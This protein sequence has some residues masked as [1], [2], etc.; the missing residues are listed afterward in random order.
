MWLTAC[1]LGVLVIAP[2]PLYRLLSIPV[3][4]RWHRCHA[5]RVAGL[6]VVYALA[7]AFLVI[8]APR[9]TLPI[10]AG[11]TVLLLIERWRARSHYGGKRQLPPGRLSLVPRRPW[12]DEAFFRGQAKRYGPIFK[13]SQY[14]RPMVCV[15]GPRLGTSLIRQN[16]ARLGAPPVRFNAFIPG[17]F[18]RY[19]NDDNHAK[20]RPVFQA[21][22][23]RRVLEANR[24]LF[25]AQIKQGLAKIS[26]ASRSPGGVHPSG[27]LNEMLFCVV[28]FLFTGIDETSQSFEEL[29]ELYRGLDIRKAGCGSV[30]NEVRLARRIA[31]ILSLRAG[32]LA[33]KGGVTPDEPPCVLSEI[34]RQHPKAARDVTVH[35]N[36]AYMI[37]IGSSDLAGLFTWMA[38]LLMDNPQW[39]GKLRV[40]DR[41]NPMLSSSDDGE[42]AGNVVKEALR[43]EQS[44][45]IFRKAREDIEFDGF[46]IPKGWLVRIC[47]RDGH[48]DAAVFNDPNQFD[49]DRFKSDNYRR[50]EYSPLGIGRHSCLGN[51]VIDVVGR[52]FAKELANAY[53]GR[54]IADGPRQYGRAHWE[55]SANLRLEL[56]P[57]Q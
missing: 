38:K 1:A 28:L 20:Y 21:A 40:T 30:N 43:L 8:F 41:Q 46:V 47:I 26:V 2:W 34:V 10:A 16:E 42:L 52:L 50:D 37:Q 29:K 55:P 9:L 24:A 45:Y 53:D 49:A 4:R 7:I 44:E 39:L 11:V 56:T 31:A 19:M 48:R 5:I 35:L 15:L 25:D 6:L 54:V 33:A 22:L 27:D 18:I 36:L 32:D 14:F 51:Q 57:R 12:V 3:F 17:G 13:M 23:N